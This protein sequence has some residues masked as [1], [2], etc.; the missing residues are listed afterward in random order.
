MSLHKTITV[1]GDVDYQVQVGFDL[2]DNLNENLPQNVD[3]VALI[4]PKEVSKT[5]KKVQKQL[6]KLSYKVIEI[7]IPSAE[8]A[9]NIKT[10]EKCWDI[11]G[12]NKFSRTDLII[13]IGGGA[14]TDLAGFVAATW[15]RGIKFISIPTTL[16][17]M[18]DAA[19]GGKTGINSNSGKNLIVAVGI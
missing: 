19:V 16:L 17:G 7:K 18:V 13:G 1:R 12:K 14:T 11:L 3:K 8:N 9:K 10:V 5:A 2:L 4:F 15:L 6:S